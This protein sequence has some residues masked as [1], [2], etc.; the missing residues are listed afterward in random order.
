MTPYVRKL[1][2]A[3]AVV[4][5]M[6][7]AQAVPA[8]ESGKRMMQLSGQ[9]A[10][11]L[12]ELGAVVIENDSVLTF[13]HV[14]PGDQRPKAY[15]DVDIAANDVLVMANGT[16]M[17]T[18]DQLTKLYDKLKPGEELKLAIRRDKDMRLVGFVKAD[19][20]SLPKV[21]TVTRTVGGPE[22]T[23]GEGRQVI[24]MDGEPGEDIMI[25]GKLGLIVTPGPDGLRIAKVLDDAKDIYSDK[26]PKEGDIIVALGAK[27]VKSPDQLDEI[28]ATITT[29]DKE[30]LSLKRGDEK[31]TLTFT[32]P[33]IAKGTG[34][35]KQD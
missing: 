28:L 2:V 1:V 34:M 20:E 7:G 22:A 35:W 18:A 23:A 33:E 5:A 21:Q 24:S 30:A 17:H 9:G 4:A 8:Q 6:L 29:G 16:R 13:M 11:N 31:L 10:F 26:L 14:M 27:A 3:G 32:C 25:L 15:K 12:A 19:P